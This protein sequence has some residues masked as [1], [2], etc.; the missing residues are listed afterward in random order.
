MNRI[1]VAASACPSPVVL[2][3]AVPSPILRGATSSVEIET[4]DGQGMQSLSVNLPYA[5][6]ASVTSVRVVRMATPAIITMESAN[7]SA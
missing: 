6:E 1:I 5:L 3:K 4:W 2:T 7:A